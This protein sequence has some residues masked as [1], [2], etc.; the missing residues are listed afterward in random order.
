MYILGLQMLDIATAWL[1][2]T[3]FLHFTHW[4]KSSILLSEAEVK[5]RKMVTSNP[6]QPEAAWRVRCPC[7]GHWKHWNTTPLSQ[8][9]FYSESESIDK[10]N[11][12]RTE[13]G[14]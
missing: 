3:A 10:Y 2:R 5:G 6:D 11:R 7:G 1:S 4:G 8:P 9:N 14:W 13:R 12:G